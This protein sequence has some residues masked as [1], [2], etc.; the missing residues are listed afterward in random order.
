I[1]LGQVD[2]LNPT[3]LT[4]G[5]YDLQAN[6]TTNNITGNQNESATLSYVVKGNAPSIQ[7]TGS[8]YSTPIQTLTTGQTAYFYGTTSP[9][10]LDYSLGTDFIANVIVESVD[11][12]TDLQYPYS[13][14]SFNATNL[15]TGRVISFATVAT[16]NIN[17]RG[18]ALDLNGDDYAIRG[19]ATFNLPGT[20]I[21]Y[22]TYGTDTYGVQEQQI[23]SQKLVVAGN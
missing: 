17:G 4:A 16:G 13:Y 23:V 1:T 7:W 11:P 15:Y 6:F 19:S 3:L 14:P 18:T 2:I 12:A 8:D 20:Y 9:L 5:T 22:L 10:G 21:V